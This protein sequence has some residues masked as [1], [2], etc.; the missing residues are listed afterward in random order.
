[1]N[2]ISA[3]V[4][5]TCFESNFAILKA[6]TNQGAHSIGKATLNGRGLLVLTHMQGDV[7]PCMVITNLRRIANLRAFIK[8]LQAAIA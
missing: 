5:A 4:I 3:R 1:V 7:F 8:S 2:F 6:G